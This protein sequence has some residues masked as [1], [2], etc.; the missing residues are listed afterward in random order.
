MRPATHK[1]SSAVMRASW[2][3]MV[4]LSDGLS[5]R[6]LRHKRSKRVGQRPS[7]VHTMR[8][9]PT[10]RHATPF[11]SLIQRIL[12][13][14]SQFAMSR[15]ERDLRSTSTILPSKIFPLF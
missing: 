12:Q 1:P 13:G 11:V 8:Y 10:T 3:G 5:N 15:E 14:G 7:L 2:L 6:N 4:P 9:D